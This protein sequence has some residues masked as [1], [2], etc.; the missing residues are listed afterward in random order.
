MYVLSISTDPVNL[1]EEAVFAAAS[2]QFDQHE[3]KDEEKRLLP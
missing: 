1:E 3:G 2:Q